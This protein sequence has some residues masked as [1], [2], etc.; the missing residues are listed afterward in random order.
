MIYRKDIDGLRAL[1]V[2]PVIIFHSNLTL[3]PGGFLGV[4]VFFVIS[5]FLIT[6]LIIKDLSKKQ[7][8][9][10]DF[11]ERRV[12]RITPALIS[13]MFF[14]LILSYFILLPHQLKDFGQSLV[15][16]SAFLSNYFF[17]LE[18]DYFNAFTNKAPLLHTWSLSV[19]EHFYLILPILLMALFKLSKNLIIWCLLMLLILSYYF[20]VTLYEDNAILGFYSSH[21]RFWELIIGSLATFWK[22]PILEKLVTLKFFN[23][24]NWVIPEILSLSALTILFFLFVSVP[25]TNAHPSINAM[26][27]LVTSILLTFSD[28]TIVVNGFLSSRLL[29]NIG[30]ISYSLYLFHQPIFSFF[31]FYQFPFTDNL[32]LEFSLA[33]IAITSLSVL[34][35]KFIES[36]IRKSKTN[37]FKTFFSVFFCFLVLT[38]IGLFIHINNGFLKYYTTKFLDQGGVLLVDVDKEKDLLESLKVSLENNS[39]GEGSKN[40]LIVGDSMAEDTFLAFSNYYRNNQDIRIKH[41]AVDDLCMR[42]FLR[43]V[44]SQILGK[45]SCLDNLKNSEIDS[46]LKASD[47]ILISAKWLDITIEDGLSLARFFA[48]TYEK[49]VA[50][51][52]TVMFQDLSSISLEFARLGISA[53]NAQKEMPKY[54]R[55]DRLRTNLKLK[56]KVQNESKVKWIDRTDFFCNRT[57]EVCKVFTDSGLPL[58]WDNV[59]LTSRALNS[60]ALFIKNI[61]N[62]NGFEFLPN[63]NGVPES[64]V[65]E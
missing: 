37:R 35:Y 47:G 11:F 40:L 53:V 33:V 59:H 8:S 32:I 49:P 6:N 54:I 51:I 13:V 14:S 18:T 56:E 61:V 48:N 23:T 38:C 1:A 60:Y 58:I 42:K 50:I 3:F 41:L 39:K 27:V 15:A 28:K 4:D 43:E 21:S 12:K 7:F 45:N 9:L 26:V 29:S 2:L 65:R 20:A 10:I 24:Y 57:Q 46:I 19:E 30:L 52:G 22:K 64:G 34:N 55:Q 36:P 17:Y 63:Q 16:T 31:H 5:G 44:S 25:N 62:K